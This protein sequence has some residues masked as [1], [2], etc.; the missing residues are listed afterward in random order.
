MA[1]LFPLMVGFATLILLTATFIVLE[2]YVLYRVKK[3]AFR[4]WIGKLTVLNLLSAFLGLHVGAY[5]AEIGFLNGK[6]LIF[7]IANLFIQLIN[8]S[9]L[10]EFL[11]SI[12][13]LILWIIVEGIGLALILKDETIRVLWIWQIVII[14]N[15]ISYGVTLFVYVLV[16]IWA[17]SG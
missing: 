5:R 2:G 9:V 3:G 14:I 16:Y 11:L 10:W 13:M 7:D 15:A 12:P 17:H 6:P 8:D 4:R 1:F